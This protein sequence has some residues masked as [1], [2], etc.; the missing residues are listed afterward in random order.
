MKKFLQWILT[1]AAIFSGVSLARAQT[2]P[3]FN[4]KKIAGTAISSPAAGACYKGGS[5]V[6]IAWSSTDQDYEILGKI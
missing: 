4:I 1:I 6:D 3:S 2:P 5:N